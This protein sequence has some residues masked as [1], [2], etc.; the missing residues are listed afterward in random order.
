MSNCFDLYII[1]EET[2]KAIKIEGLESF[3]TKEDNEFFTFLPYASS[4]VVGLNGI[5]ERLD[6][7][8]QLKSYSSTMEFKVLYGTDK[9]EAIKKYRE[10]CVE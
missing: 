3:C 4:S 9:K 7:L 5:K 2:Y 8:R 6:T 1:R 10:E